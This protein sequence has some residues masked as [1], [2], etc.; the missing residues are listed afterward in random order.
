M[1]KKCKLRPIQIENIQVGWILDIYMKM[2]PSKGPENADGD[3]EGSKTELEGPPTP[4][5]GPARLW[6]PAYVGTPVKVE[7]LL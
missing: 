3:G 5:K 4:N 6:T 2:G 1:L 7:E